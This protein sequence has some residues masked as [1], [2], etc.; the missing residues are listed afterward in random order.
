M[1]FVLTV[2][3]RIVSESTFVPT[4]M[5]IR[6]DVIRKW[7][8][9]S[10]N[11]LFCYCYLFGVIIFETTSECLVL[12]ETL[13]IYLNGLY[14]EFDILFADGGGGGV[15]RV[16][17]SLEPT[18]LHRRLYNTSIDNWISTTV[19]FSILFI[20]TSSVVPIRFFHTAR[21]KQT[22]SS[23]FSLFLVNAKRPPAEHNR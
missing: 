13:R 17:P 2:H 21:Y 9:F 15:R 14:F 1:G 10:K 7:N 16:S 11:C 6:F 18:A 12:K 20:Y 22:I 8:F 3:A 4:Y 5:Y 19:Y 23:F